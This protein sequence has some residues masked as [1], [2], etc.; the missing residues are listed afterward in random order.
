[1]AVKQDAA[2]ARY[3]QNLIREAARSGLSNSGVLSAW[4]GDD[5]SVLLGSDRP[6]ARVT[7]SSRWL[8]YFLLSCGRG[9]GS[10]VGDALDGEIVEIW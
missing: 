9:F 2:K 10:E 3:W 7:G 5:Q 4:A 8:G 1:M 6:T